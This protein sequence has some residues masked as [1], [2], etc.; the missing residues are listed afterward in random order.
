MMQELWGMQSILSNLSFPGALWPGV[1]TPDT[2]LS[3]GQTELNSSFES[4]LF[5]HLNY[6]FMLN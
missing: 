2:V 4:L 5:L 1:V 6:I 3:M